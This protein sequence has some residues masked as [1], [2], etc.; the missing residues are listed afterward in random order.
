MRA[1]VTMYGDLTADGPPSPA[2][3]ALDLLRA[4]AH[5]C[6]H[7]GSART[8]QMRDGAVIRT[9]YGVNFRRVGGRTYSAPDLTGTT[10]TRNLGVVME[11]AC[12]REARVITRHVAAQHRI[13][14]D[15][16]IDAYALRDVT[17]QHTTIEA[18]PG[19]STEQAAY[20]TSMAKYEAGVDARYVAFLADIGGA[21]Q[22]DLHSLILASMISGDLVPLCTWLDRRHGP[23]SFAALFMSPLYL[24]NTE[25]VL[26]S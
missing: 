11:G 4:Y 26:A 18:P 5:D 2:L 8:Y 6:L 7:Y 17:G 16:G 15:S 25:M 13:S 10:G 24:G 21:E 9:Q 3:A 1:V 20:L 14:A 12:D 19:L 22:E 23:G